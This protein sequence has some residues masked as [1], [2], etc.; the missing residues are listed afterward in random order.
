M[1]DA[2][3]VPLPG[4][5]SAGANTHLQDHDALTAAITELRDTVE[6]LTSVAEALEARIGELEHLLD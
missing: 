5:A 6:S 4:P 3:T 1:A 2:W